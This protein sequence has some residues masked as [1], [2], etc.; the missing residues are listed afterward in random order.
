MR[1]EPPRGVC[2]MALTIRLS[3]TCSIRSRS[4]MTQASSPST[5]VSS[6]MPASSA[7]DCIRAA[8]LVDELDGED[9]LEVQLDAALLD[10][11]Q[12]EQVVDHGQDAIGILARRQQ[13]LDLFRRERAH[14]LF[15]Q[16]VD[17][18]L[19]AGQ[20][21]LQ[22]VADGRDHVALQPI[23]QVE[24]GH[25]QEGDRGADQLVGR[26][27]DRHDARQEVTFLAAVGERNRLF[28]RV[29]EVVA[30]AGQHVV[31][32]GF[33]RRRRIPGDGGSVAGTTPS[34]RRAAGL[35]CSTEPA[36]STTTT[37]SGNESIVAWARLLARS[38]RAVPACR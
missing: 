20:R 9:R 2:W 17:G 1:I 28:E 30:P 34:S 19:H 25:V 11:G 13:Q 7:R 24:L 6:V 16:E 36:R 37:G 27:P 22:L 32:Q 31:D 21:R 18:H 14:D 8:A 29:R 3:K 23:E 4:T 5:S 38:S 12:V 35:A 10:P 33:Q 15:E 26:R